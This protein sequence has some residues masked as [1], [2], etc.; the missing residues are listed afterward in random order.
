[1]IVEAIYDIEEAYLVSYT[2]AAPEREPERARAG[3]FDDWLAETVARI[4]ERQE[5]RK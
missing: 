4:D 3:R 2:I 5:R 1:M